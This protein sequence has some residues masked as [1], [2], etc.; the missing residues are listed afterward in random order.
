M[1]QKIKR[2]YFVSLMYKLNYTNWVI[3]FVYLKLL[4]EKQGFTQ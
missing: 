4:G 3:E 1:K 2:C